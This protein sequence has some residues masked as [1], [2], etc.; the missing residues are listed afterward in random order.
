MAVLESKDLSYFLVLED[1]FNFSLLIVLPK[2]IPDRHLL[3]LEHQ[4]TQNQSENQ[5]LLHDINNSDSLSH[6]KERQERKII[7]TY[8]GI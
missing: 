1:S 7:K 2:M 6:N 4:I 8:A 3:Y 5:I